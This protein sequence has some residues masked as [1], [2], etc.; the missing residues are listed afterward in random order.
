MEYQL[1]QEYPL[2]NLIA[3]GKN[4]NGWAVM[5]EGEITAIRFYSHD[6]AE[7]VA[8]SA[9]LQSIVEAAKAKGKVG[10]YTKPTTI[11][12]GM[13]RHGYFRVNQRLHHGL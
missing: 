12:T 6:R 9:E 7:R 10:S 3:A 11:L 8:V 4:G 13:V 1:L 5:V 2:G